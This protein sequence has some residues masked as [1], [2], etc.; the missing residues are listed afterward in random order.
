MADIAQ[1]KRTFGPL[2]FHPPRR[3]KKD[4]FMGRFGGGWQYNL[5][6]QMG[7]FDKREGCTFIVNYLV[8]SIRIEYRPK[9]S[10]RRDW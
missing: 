7:N 2:R 5:G 10:S 8:D 6:V 4:E 3:R 9:S 1:K